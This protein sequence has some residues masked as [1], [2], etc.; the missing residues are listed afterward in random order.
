VLLVPERWTQADAGFPRN[1]CCTNPCVC[2]C[3]GG[4]CR[5]WVRILVS[6]DHLSHAAPTRTEGTE[7]EIWMGRFFFFTSLPR[8]LMCISKAFGRPACDIFRLLLPFLF[9]SIS[10]PS[11]LSLYVIS[12]LHMNLFFCILFL[13]LSCFSCFIYF[14]L[15]L[16]AHSIPSFF[17]FLSFLLSL[18]VLRLLSYLLLFLPLFIN[19]SHCR[20]HRRCEVDIQVTVLQTSLKPEVTRSIDLLAH[21]LIHALEV[22]LHWLFLSGP[23]VTRS[24]CLLFSSNCE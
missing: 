20:Q 18:F 5:L 14:L 22:H 10:F 17:G 9:L 21:L 1:T 11:P 7:K 13:P 3:N 24:L 12:F 16:F 4:A 23:D 8:I 6:T 19:R 2:V 15:S